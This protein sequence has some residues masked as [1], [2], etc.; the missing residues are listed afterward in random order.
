VLNLVGSA[1]MLLA[2][3]GIYATTGTLNMADVARRLA[4]AGEFGIDPA[5][6]LGLTGILFAV[7][8]LK[9]GIAPFQFWVPDTYRAAPAPV[10][11][12]LAG[13][14]KKVG[15]YAI[16]RLLFTILPAAQIT[17]GLS[18]SLFS[19]TAF[20][21]FFGP[22]LFVMAVASILVG[23]F[24]A[25]SHDH[26]D[27]IL[28]HSSIGQVGFII[29]PLAIA[30]TVPGVR[31]LGIAAALVYAVNHSIAKS[32]LFLVSG[33]IRDAAGTVELDRIGGIAGQAPVLSGGFFL[34]ALALVGIP[35][36]TGFFGKFLVFDVATRAML[37]DARLAG[38]ALLCAL[39]GAILTI[40]YLSRAW[41]TC[42]W[43]DPTDLV[44]RA[45]VSGALVAVTA[46]FALA[47][48]LFG[49]GFDPIMNS[50]NAAADAAVAHDAYVE[51]VDP[52]EVSK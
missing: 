30:A 18:G 42:F 39:F 4:A 51:A 1:I 11:A 43:G 2:I 24:G 38:V 41:N 17:G 9:A 37:V 29:L 27:G 49:I 25:V 32:L 36:L 13:V 50:A 47:V 21:A 8:A 33:T 26:L 3:G 28:A 44:E 34:G 15:V 35:P 6:V 46:I 16:V 14:T 48:L 45:H 7:F 19:G 12:M 31:E 10:A 20:L 5:P 23:G 52:Q 22:V 40:A